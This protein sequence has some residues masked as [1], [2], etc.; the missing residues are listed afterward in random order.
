MTG[1]SDIPCSLFWRKYTIRQKVLF[2]IPRRLTNHDT[3]SSSFDAIQYP[4]FK[5][6]RYSQ[7]H[8]LINKNTQFNSNKLTNQM[9]QFYKFIT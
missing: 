2:H 4:Q 5:P 6:R 9:Q 8:T 1:I 7:I 3:H